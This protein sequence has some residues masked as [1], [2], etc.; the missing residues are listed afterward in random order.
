[1]DLSHLYLDGSKFEANA[2]KY[3]WVWKKSCL[4]NRL[5]LFSRVTDS[6]KE[7]N[8]NLLNPEGITF[9]LKEEYAI[10][11]LEEKLNFL[12]KHYHID[13]FS[14]SVNGRGHSKSLL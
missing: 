6:L 13:F 14:T 2:N 9:E 12:A 4:T 1:M 3:S 10:E 5:K 8:L 7:I 11:Y